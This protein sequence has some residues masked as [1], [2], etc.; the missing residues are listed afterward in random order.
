M[1]SHSHSRKHSLQNMNGVI[2]LMK[3]RDHAS[4]LEKK[5]FLALT[6]AGFSWDH[7]KFKHQYFKKEDY[8]ALSTDKAPFDTPELH[9]ARVSV[10]NKFIALHELIKN[11]LP[12]LG[13]HAN[14]RSGFHC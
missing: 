10:Q 9:A 11:D 4:R 12:K 6:T 7:I 2:L 13:L 3:Q 5:Q 8:L 14:F 1:N